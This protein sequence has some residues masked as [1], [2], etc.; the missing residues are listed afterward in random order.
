LSVA[1]QKDRAWPAFPA[2]ARRAL[3]TL[4]VN[5]GYRC[6]QSCSHCHVDAGPKR[7]ESMDRE[8]VDLVLRF[9]GTRAIEN[10]DVTGG[11]P[12]LNPHFRYLV[13]AA[14]AADVHV[15]DRCNL[16]VLEQPG[17][18]DLAEFLA[19]QGVHIIAS[20]PCY[21][22][23][24]VDRQRGKGVFESSMRG[25]RQLNRVGFGRADSGLV[26]DFVYN[27]VGPHLPPDTAALEAD[28]KRELARSGIV[29]NRLLTITNMPINRFRHELMRSGELDTYMETLFDAYRA[30]N[31]DDVM[32]RTLLS[33]DWRGFVY[34]CDFNQ[35]L[36][37]QMGG[38]DAL[39]LRDLLDVSL[40]G[41]D[42]AVG[43]HCFGCTAG[44]GSS[45]SGA[46]SA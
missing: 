19:Q 34:D 41:R 38:R 7:T 40:R 24:N 20:L 23:E 33:V 9:V 37:L 18:G 6:N 16:T 26:L 25:I 17:Q 14:R 43:A 39:H 3:D 36:G 46:L 13:G 45:C 4:Q 30:A 27:P 42:I 8:T 1:R 2:I 35:M 29:F 12:E 31:L 10:L 22:P 5:L 15:I 32:C 21:T 44:R 11:A 28:Y